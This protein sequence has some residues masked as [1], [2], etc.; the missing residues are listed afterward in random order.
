MDL[1]INMICSYF[2]L[3]FPPPNSLTRHH[4]AKDLARSYERRAPHIHTPHLRCWG[5]A[6]SPTGTLT[7]PGAAPWNSV[8]W[9]VI[10]LLSHILAHISR[11]SSL[12]SFGSELQS[13]FHS[14]WEWGGYWPRLSPELQALQPLL[15]MYFTAF[16]FPP[17]S[18]V[19]ASNCG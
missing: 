15:Q 1:T 6:S 7:F 16:S 9:A 12:L 4:W 18:T 11:G 3:F 14:T 2:L 13:V 8:P 19:V 5:P 10:P 17:C